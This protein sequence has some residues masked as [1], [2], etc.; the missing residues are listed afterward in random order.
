M[1]KIHKNWRIY[2]SVFFLFK[3]KFLFGYHT[4]IPTWTNKLCL[5]Q[6]QKNQPST[7]KKRSPGLLGSLITALFQVL[8]DTQVSASRRTLENLWAANY[9]FVL[10]E[11]NVWG[12]ICPQAPHRPVKRGRSRN[13]TTALLDSRLNPPVRGN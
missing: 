4:A 5:C 1:L 6:Q 2:L 13:T 11:E 12:D 3:H 8:E 9:S 7:K 10:R